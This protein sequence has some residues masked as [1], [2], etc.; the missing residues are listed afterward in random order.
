MDR[1]RRVSTQRWS[2]LGG[3]VVFPSTYPDGVHLDS[4]GN[5][6]LDAEG[7]AIL[8][9]T[10]PDPDD[11]EIV[12]PSQYADMHPEQRTE[13]R[14]LLHERKTKDMNIH[15]Y[16]SILVDGDYVPPKSDSESSSGGSDDDSGS[17][18]SDDDG[19]SDEDEMMVDWMTDIG[20][21]IDDLEEDDLTTTFQ[22]DAEFDNMSDLDD[23]I[24]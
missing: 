17:E 21:V 23:V 3:Y 24:E 8:S 12:H 6:I 4:D 15:G 9:D 5:M 10:I 18:W 2:H 13:Q 14:M 11:V 19:M 16:G 22:S 1:P 7:N 20:N